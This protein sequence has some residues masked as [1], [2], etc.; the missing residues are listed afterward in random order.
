MSDMQTWLNVMTESYPMG[1]DADNNTNVS[2]NQSK[3][4][5][6]ATLNIHATAKDMEELQKVLQ[7]AGLDPEGAEKH[8]P[9]PD[10][11]KVVSV[12][13]APAPCGDDVKYSTDKQALVDVLRNKLQSR[14]G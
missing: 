7:M 4:I 13:P 14:L 2:F 9:E 1:M 11:V 12:D 10:S 3:K 5:G 8:M 6:D